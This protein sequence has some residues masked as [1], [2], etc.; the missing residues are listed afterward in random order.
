MKSH[1]RLY[2]VALMPDTAQRK[3]VSEIKQHIASTY[4]LAH[5][6]KSPPHIT[7]YPPFALEI[8]REKHL[9]EVLSDFVTNQLSFRLKI[10][11]FGKFSP[12]VI[13]LRV[14][15]TGNM[16]PL[17][18]SLRTC[19]EESLPLLTRNT[20]KPYR[21]HM[22]VATR[23]HERLLFDRVWNDMQSR[24]I[25]FDFLADAL[26]LLRHNGQTWDVIH[27]LPFGIPDNR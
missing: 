22:T 27:K 20:N 1:E 15:G 6:L 3:L 4:G 2:F 10:H 8:N 18:E 7:M 9:I 21:P 23:I 12:K 5:A 26:Y 17:E 14:S 25:E 24:E 11:G 13:Y 19:M 16:M